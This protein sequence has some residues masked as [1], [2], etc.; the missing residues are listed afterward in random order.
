MARKVESGKWSADLLRAD[1]DYIEG[2]KVMH[3]AEEENATDALEALLEILLD[4][5]WNEKEVRRITSHDYVSGILMIVR[6][7]GKSAIVARRYE[8]NFDDPDICRISFWGSFEDTDEAS[9]AA[10]VV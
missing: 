4:A 1:K 7:S 5:Y 6:S 3:S 9:N 10:V 2:V 8:R